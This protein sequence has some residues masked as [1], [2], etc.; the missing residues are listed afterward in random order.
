MEHGDD[1]AELCV[2]DASNRVKWDVADRHVVDTANVD[3]EVGLMNR[4]YKLDIFTC[5]ATVGTPVNK[6]AGM[7]R[8]VIL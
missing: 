4:G 2:D 7:S 3:S 1:G 6:R 5:D 8:E